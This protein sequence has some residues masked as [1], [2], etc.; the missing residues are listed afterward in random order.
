MVY[1]LHLVPH[2][3]ADEGDT[4][5]ILMLKDLVK[6]YCMIGMSMKDHPCAQSSVFLFSVYISYPK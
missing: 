4:K 6:P 5:K 3:Y 2:F 1:G